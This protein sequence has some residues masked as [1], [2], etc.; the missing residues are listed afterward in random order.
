VIIGGHYARRQV[1]A[2]EP[3]RGGERRASAITTGRERSVSFTTASIVRSSP[4]GRPSS[5]SRATAQVGWR[6]GRSKAQAIA[7]AVVSAR[8]SAASPAR[9]A[10]GVGEPVAILVL[11]REKQGE[12][13]VVLHR[14]GPARGGWRSAR[15]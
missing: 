7:V 13:V 9:R 10:V 15:R 11:D 5:R 4:A 3:C 2:A 8:R 6:T 12:H 14:A 1:V